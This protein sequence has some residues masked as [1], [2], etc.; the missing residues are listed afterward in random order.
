MVGSSGWG[1][2]VRVLLVVVTKR[3]IAALALFFL[4]VSP[5][6][7]ERACQSS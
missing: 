1:V 6:N 7:P 5:S 4:T 2:R 3:S